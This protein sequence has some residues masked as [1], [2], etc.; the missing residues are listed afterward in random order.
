MAEII[1]R[2]QLEWI[3]GRDPWMLVT[4]M[5]MYSDVIGDELVVPAGFSC[6]LASVPRVPFVYARYGNTAVLPAIVHD[7]MYSCMKD[8]Y[9][10]RQ[11]D[12]LFYELMTLLNDPKG[13]AQRWV[14]YKAVRGAGW[15]PWRRGD[16]RSC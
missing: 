9:T 8:K 13:A 2:P 6:D 11:A 5:I 4:P 14:M 15:L 10:R 16:S 7:Y 12:L 3:G 1:Q